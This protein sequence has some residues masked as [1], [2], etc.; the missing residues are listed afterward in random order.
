MKLLANKPLLVAG[1]VIAEG[2]IFTVTEQRGR[3]LVLRDF[4]TLAEIKAVEGNSQNGF[5]KKTQQ[6]VR[7]KKEVDDADS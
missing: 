2:E 7:G 5:I 4:A 6:R 3:D 1:D